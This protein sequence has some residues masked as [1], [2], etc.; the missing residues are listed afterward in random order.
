MKTYC[1][2]IDEPLAVTGGG[3]GSGGG[4]PG[5]VAKLPP[6]NKLT[7]VHVNCTDDLL[8]A[9]GYTLCVR[10]CDLA[11]GKVHLT[12]KGIPCSSRALWFADGTQ[13]S[14]GSMRSGALYSSVALPVELAALHEGA[15]D[16]GFLVRAACACEP[17]AECL[18]TDGQDQ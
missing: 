6:F 14:R 17:T 3:G 16:E 8:L 12:R 2:L 5:I 9:S 15:G 10:L 18:V 11:T 1:T 7:S 13:G 4:G